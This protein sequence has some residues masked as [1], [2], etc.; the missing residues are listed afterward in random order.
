MKTVGGAGMYMYTAVG[1]RKTGAQVTL[2]A[3]RPIRMHDLLAPIAATTTWVGPEVDIE[4]FPKLE[5]AHYG[6]G[7]AM[8]I[9][10]AWGVEV[11]LQS[12]EISQFL[13]HDLS[14]FDA[15]HIAALSSAQR[16]LDFLRACRALGGS[17]CLLVPMGAASMV[18]P[19][20]SRLCYVKP[21]YF[22]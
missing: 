1:T 4:F 2:L 14:L 12:A 9:D 13:P 20:L 5:I 16:Q 22:L 3:P 8:L 21:I 17:V 18:R 7:Q 6:N 10:A 15:I 19:M 11:R